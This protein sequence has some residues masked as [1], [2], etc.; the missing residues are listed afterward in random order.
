MSQLLRPTQ[1]PTHTVVTLLEISLAT[2][3]PTYKSLDCQSQGDPVGYSQNALKTPLWDYY[4]FRL[5]SCRF[6]LVRLLLLIDHRFAFVTQPLGIEPRSFG[7]KAVGVTF[8]PMAATV[9]TFTA[10]HSSI[11]SGSTCDHDKDLTIRQT[12]FASIGLTLL[13]STAQ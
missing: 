5:V 1:T 9:Y 7:L 8:T 4:F 10:C 6:L 3:Q 11:F 12:A 13:P 2:Q